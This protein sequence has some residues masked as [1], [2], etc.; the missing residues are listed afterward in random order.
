M[1]GERDRSEDGYNVVIHEFA[2]VLDMHHGGVDGCPAL[3]DR[4]MRTR[5]R[6]VMA[7][8][9]VQHTTEVDS[10][11]P[12][13]LDPYAA[14]GPEEFFPVTAE[15]FF[16]APDGLQAEFP[17]VYTLLSVYFGQDP[18]RFQT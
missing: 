17:E 9:L 15:A 13:W 3:P 4:A 14:Q 7:R 12:T 1:A 6:D 5:W 2:H 16:V 10:G 11:Q 8:A 18:V